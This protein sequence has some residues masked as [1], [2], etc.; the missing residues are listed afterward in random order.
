[1][2]DLS[3]VYETSEND[4]LNLISKIGGFVHITFL[5]FYFVLYYVE[6][7]SLIFHAIESLY[8][9]KSK[10]VDNDQKW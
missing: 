5:I 10:Q 1:M 9:M 7:Y 6:K 2:G 8:E 4:I 3:V